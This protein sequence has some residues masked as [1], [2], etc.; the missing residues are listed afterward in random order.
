MK[1]AWQAY[2]NL[3]PH[4]MRQDVD[5]LGKENLQELRLRVGLFPE[6]ISQHFV[7][8]IDRVVTSSDLS[9]VINSASDYSPWAATTISEGYL[10]AEGG[11]RIGICGVCTVNKGVVTGIHQPSSLCIRVSRDFDDIASALSGLQTS[12][13]IIGSPGSGKTTFLRDLVRK[14]SNRTQGSVSVVDERE[15]IFPI[16]KGHACYF[17]GN[18]TDILSGCSKSVGINAVLRSMNP[19]W[20]VVDEI[21]AEKDTQALLQAGWCGVKLIATAHASSIEELLSRP[22]YRILISEQLFSDIVIMQKDK[23]WKKERAL[24]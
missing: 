20:I 7:H 6:L 18:R 8:K 12:L 1:C 19:E 5:R 16:I 9:F 24:I 14:V 11:H 22:M 21:T 10:T 13:L 23:S 17:A 2:I 4:W 3:L 15:E